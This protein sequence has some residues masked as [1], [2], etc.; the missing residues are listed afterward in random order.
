MPTSG[1]ETDSACA[2]VSGRVTSL[3]CA[4]ATPEDAAAA[5]LAASLPG[6]LRLRSIAEA[7]VSTKGTR[8]W[9]G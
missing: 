2:L 8:M 4:D 5:W 3:R 7:M 9:V 1:L 6:A